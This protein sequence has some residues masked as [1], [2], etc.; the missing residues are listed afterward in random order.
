MMKLGNLP[1]FLLC[2]LFSFLVIHKELTEY[3]HF[4]LVSSQNIL[5]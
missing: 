4:D 1:G 5:F 3:C 2:C